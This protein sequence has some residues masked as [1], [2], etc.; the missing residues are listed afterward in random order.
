MTGE[1]DD[2]AD[3]EATGEGLTHLEVMELPVGTTVEDG[4]GDRYLRL[5]PLPSFP[6]RVWSWI[7]VDAGWPTLTAADLLRYGP[8]KIVSTP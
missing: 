1:R 6:S 8:V 2:P 3:Y 4:D 5:E 7:G